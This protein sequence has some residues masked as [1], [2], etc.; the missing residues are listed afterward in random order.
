[1]SAE[2]LEPVGRWLWVPFAP[3]GCLYNERK[4]LLSFRWDRLP[5]Q[6]GLQSQVNKKYA[7]FHFNLNRLER[8]CIV[9]TTTDVEIHSKSTS[10]FRASPQGCSSNQD[11]INKALFLNCTLITS[12]TVLFHFYC[13]FKLAYLS[14]QRQVHMSVHRS[15]AN[16]WLKVFIAFLSWHTGLLLPLLF[17]KAKEAD[18]ACL[19]L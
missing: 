1:M 2:V 14:C 16:E 8:A 11:S 10:W 15:V 13:I 4:R 17:G 12:L 7:L 5:K 18:W 19:H 3:H 6:L 9:S